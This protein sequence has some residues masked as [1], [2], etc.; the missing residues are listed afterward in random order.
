M[1]LSAQSRIRWLVAVHLVLAAAPLLIL[2]VP[3]TNSYFMY[4]IPLMWVLISIPFGSMLTASI[5][6]GLG[7]ARW[8]WRLFFG[9]LACFYV[10]IWFDLYEPSTSS[11]SRHFADYLMNYLETVTGLCSMVLPAGCAF[12]IVARWFELKVSDQSTPPAKS[13]IRFSLLQILLLM[14]AV[15]IVLSLM[16]AVRSSAGNEQRPESTAHEV[17][18]YA[19]LIVIEFINSAL[20]VGAAL[21]PGKFVGRVAMVLLVSF[22]L[23][24]AIA[25][26]MGQDEAS[27]WLFACS[28][29]IAIVPTL[30]VV[31]SLLVVRSCGYRLVR[32][33]RRVD[34]LTGCR[35]SAKETPGG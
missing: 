10:A 34:P 24:A 23:G 31:L 1:P 33:E 8:P 9:L 22:V 16:H 19:F 28:M 11:G 14:S 26:G 5:W 2:L 7:K 15:A 27:W 18:D 13:G 3:T 20:A 30:V 12:M 35:R 25:L 4:F 17:A 6:I 32:R 21:K 29:L